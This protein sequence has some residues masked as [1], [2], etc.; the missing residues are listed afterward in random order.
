MVRTF[1][2]VTVVFLCDAPAAHAQAWVPS[3]GEGAVSIQWQNM[4]TKDHFVP[5]YRVDI[6]HVQSNVMVIDV[7]YGVTDK[8][9]L[10]VSLPYIAS[11]YTGTQ[12]HPTRL[13]DGSYH[14]TLQDLRFAVR[15]NVRAGRLALTP[16]V[17]TIMPSHD[18]EF[19]AH[20]APGRDLR[21]F[22]IGTFVAKLVD[23]PLPGLFVSTRVAYGFQESVQNIGHGR[24]MLDVEIGQFVTDRFRAFAI[25]AGQLTRGG[26]DI[27]IGPGGLAIPLALLP[28]HDQI[29]KT[30]YLNVGGGASF[31]LGETVDIFGSIVTNV[32]NRNGHAL[33]RGIDVGIS[34]AFKQR[35]TPSAADLARA[36]ALTDRDADARS[37]V[38]CVCQRGGG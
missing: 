33:N 10:D 9:A 38:R 26:I 22:Q 16:Y 34:W 21:E 18:Y 2:L 36:A 30:H 15:Y 28:Y 24:G 5:T 25:G 11:K 35:R 3:R 13:D 27:G 31:S 23:A 29:D 20:A 6:G 32:A 8:L 14:A 4:L 7:T 12:P 1:L 17:G 19:F 37:L